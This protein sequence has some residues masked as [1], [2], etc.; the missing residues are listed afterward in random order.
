MRVLI[1]LTLMT[2]VE[3]PTSAEQLIT[4]GI[5]LTILKWDLRSANEV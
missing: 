1:L 3:P 4:D 5:E 2:P